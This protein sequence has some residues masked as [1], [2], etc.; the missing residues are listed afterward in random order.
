MKRDN[1][2]SSPRA[3]EW[4]GSRLYL[5]CGSLLIAGALATGVIVAPASADAPA[6]P[7][8]PAA[9]SYLTTTTTANGVDGGTSLAGDGYYELFDGFADFG[10]TIDG[11][12]AL[13]ATG[14]DNATLG[15]VV[16]FIEHGS[17]ASGRT[18]ADWTGTSPA[19]EVGGAFPFVSSGAI[20][21]EALLAEVV[22]DDPRAFGG[23]DLIADLDQ[24]VCTAV[25]SDPN[26]PICAAPGNY[27]NSSSTF[28]QTLGVMA[29]LRAGGDA[30]AAAPIAYLQSLQEPSGAW[31][32]AIP[33]LGDT[34]VD[35]TA[36]AVMALALAPGQAAADAVASGQAW[37]AQQ[38]QSDGGFHGAAGHSTNSAAL[39]LMALDLDRSA[40]ADQITAGLSFLAAQQ[41]PDG[42][43]NIAV[44]QT[45]SDVRASA[46]V[47]GGIV[48]TSFG[49]LLHPISPP[50]VSIAVPSD[51]A[52]YAP[53]AVPAVSFSCTAG[54]NA[55]LRSGLAGCSAVAD[56]GAPVA[57]G[58]ALP[59]SP[60]PH[61]V[62]VT[63]A[64]TDQQ[65]A[66]RQV[67]YTVTAST[68]T[69]TT[70]TGTTP[71]TTT[72]P[73][74]TTKPPPS[75]RPAR[76]V[77]ISGRRQSHRV[78]AEP[79]AH[80][81]RRPTSTTFT[82]ELNLPARLT[83]TFKRVQRGRVAGRSV[84]RTGH[85]GLNHV[86]FTGRM[87]NGRWLPAGRYELV[88]TARGAAGHTSTS[89]PLRFT[90]LAGSDS[91]DGDDSPLS[92]TVG[93]GVRTAG[94]IACTTSQSSALGA[95]VGRWPRG[96]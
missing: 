79:G 7:D 48:G 53:G 93:A 56:G 55:A 15:T 10:L 67:S 16:D 60:G 17:D 49:T 44:G 87:G 25:S 65:T 42:G 18:V 57:S 59:S 29:Q 14:S 8:L 21:K 27:Q 62:T 82:F 64:D 81:G 45:G 68:T 30:N 88:V 92:G 11:A 95:S 41:N 63:A 71:T 85:P 61:H 46:Q 51:G 52:Q 89:R 58:S 4:F 23:Q 80:A 96:T 54:A 90:I 12:L 37:I 28:D 2:A 40:Y 3:N 39:A 31:S 22:G 94:E 26:G 36:M 74:T 47:V 32:S 20:G 77:H 72:P 70:P 9:V 13:A 33:S 86:Q 19:S 24:E 6:T 84:R 50:T 91:A 78:W 73:V 75:I 76:H 66:S 43:F 1:G 38:Q 34:D 35:S 69:T 5:T 83:M